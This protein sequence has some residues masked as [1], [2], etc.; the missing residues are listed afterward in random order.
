MGSGMR[1]VPSAPPQRLNTLIAA[2]QPLMKPKAGCLALHNME[3][4]FQS[5]GAFQDSLGPLVNST[6]Q[7]PDCIAV[8]RQLGIIEPFTNRHVRPEELLI[9]SENYRES[10]TAEGCLSRHRAV[11]MLLERLYGSPQGLAGERVYLAEALTGFARRLQQWVP[12][13]VLSEYLEGATE[14]FSDGVRHEDLCA[15]SFADAAFDLV[16]TNELF[17]H[18]HSLDAALG[19]IARVLKPGGR[20]ICTFPFAYGQ[21]EQIRKAVRHPDDG[22]V[23]LL[24]ELE[25]HGDPIRPQ[26]GSMVYQVPGWSILDQ[27]R[28]LGFTRA[29]MHAIASWKHGVLGSEIPAIFVMEAER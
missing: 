22:R 26:Q 7:I 12:D 24:A 3:L 21:H 20:M 4:Q 27:A 28:T 2:S 1:R 18:V 13:V 8:I 11:L 6:R 10:I 15:L 16:I 5:F 23:E 14:S 19:E 17:E 25:L 29:C 9:G